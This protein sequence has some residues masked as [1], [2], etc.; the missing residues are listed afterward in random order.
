MSKAECGNELRSDHLEREKVMYQTECDTELIEAIEVCL[1]EC[2]NYDKTGRVCS[3]T[4]CGNGQPETLYVAECEYD[5]QTRE[6]ALCQTQCGTAQVCGRRDLRLA[7][8]A[9]EGETGTCK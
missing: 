7:E 9:K 1:P 6:Q 4:E 8:C 3:K 5:D 2:G